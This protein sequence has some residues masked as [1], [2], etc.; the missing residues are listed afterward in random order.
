MHLTL[1]ACLLALSSVYNPTS[2]RYERQDIFTSFCISHPVCQLYS[3]YCRFTGQHF[4][5]PQ[6]FLFQGKYE[7]LPVS[8]SAWGQPWLLSWVVPSS[9]CQR[10]SLYDQET[11]PHLLQQQNFLRSES[12]QPFSSP[13]DIESCPR[14]GLL[15]SIQH[16][17]PPIL[18]T[19]CL[20]ACPQTHP[21]AENPLIPG[22]MALCLE[23]QDS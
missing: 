22:Q 5:A 15:S 18:P 14:P 4:D 9:V 12:F 20:S 8:H 10:L 19:C 16:E 6:T 17:S 11:S 1:I 7:V 2:P 13:E 23:D 3:L 21:T